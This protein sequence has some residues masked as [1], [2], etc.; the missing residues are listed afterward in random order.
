MVIVAGLAVPAAVQVGLPLRDG[1]DSSVP[2][3]GV[4]WMMTVVPDP[5]IVATIAAGI[6]ALSGFPAPYRLEISASVRTRFQMARS[7]IS[8][9]HWRPVASGFSPIMT[10]LEFLA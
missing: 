3:A 4:H 7:S 2:P 6:S 8:P 10:F 1:V 9:F 5:V